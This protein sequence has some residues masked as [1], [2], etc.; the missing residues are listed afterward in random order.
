MAQPLRRSV[1]RRFAPRSGP[2][3]RAGDTI[4]TILGVFHGGQDW[5]AAMRFDADPDECTGTLRCGRV[6]TNW[7]PGRGSRLHPEGLCT[8]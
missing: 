4:V 6:A 1:G 8:R 7:V 3:A 5:E 2:R